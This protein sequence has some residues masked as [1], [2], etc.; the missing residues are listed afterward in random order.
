M[1][2]TKQPP[3]WRY[4]EKF[5]KTQLRIKKTQKK[6]TIKKFFTIGIVFFGSNKV[7]GLRGITSPSKQVILTAPG[8]PKKNQLQIN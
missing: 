6:K 7:V 4:V 1:G 3:L 8:L 2:K 5:R